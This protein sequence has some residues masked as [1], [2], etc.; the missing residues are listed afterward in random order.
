MSDNKAGTEDDI[1]V[2]ES[3][4]R[5]GEEPAV[6]SSTVDPPPPPAEEPKKRETSTFTSRLKSLNPLK[7]LGKGRKEAVSVPD[8]LQQ[9]EQPPIQTEGDTAVVESTKDKE[10][11]GGKIGKKLRLKLGKFK[12]KSTISIKEESV[13]LYIL[14]KAFELGS[15]FVLF[16]RLSNSKFYVPYSSIF[17]DY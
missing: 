5:E 12:G 3:E 13:K 1:Q 9:S 17:R 4:T 14:H 8:V 11:E 2:L 10:S 7:S 6:S 15:I 16:Q